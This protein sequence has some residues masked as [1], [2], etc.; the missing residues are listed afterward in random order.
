[1]FKLNYL[2]W[3]KKVFSEATD[4][5]GDKQDQDESNLNVSLN[6]KSFGLDTFK[7]EGKTTGS[8]KILPVNDNVILSLNSLMHT[9]LNQGR[10]ASSNT[11]N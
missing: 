1:M 6:N 4:Q 9:S 11:S 3:T 5:N 7:S 10:L 2:L 8:S